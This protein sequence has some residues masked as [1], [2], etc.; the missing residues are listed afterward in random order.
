MVIVPDTTVKL[1]KNV[2]LNNTYQH[3]IYFSSLANQSAFFSGKQKFSLS[4]YSFVKTTQALRVGLSIGQLY[5]VNYMMFQNS[6]FNSKWFYAFITNVE[7]VNNECTEIT[8]ELDA[9]QSWFFEMQLKPSFVVREHAA[10]DGIGENTVPEGDELGV[11]TSRN[12]QAVSL[13]TDATG[14]TSLDIIVFFRSKSNPN[15]TVQNNIVSPL[16]KLTFSLSDPGGL[17]AFN[18]MLQNYKD[19]PEAIVAIYEVPTFINANRP[20]RNFNYIWNKTTIDGY[21]PKNNKLF[22]YPYNYLFASNHCGATQ[23]YA[24]ENFS[25]ASAEFL[26]EGTAYSTPVVLC[27]PK[28]YRNKPVDRDSGI[29]YSNFPSIPWVG[30]SFQEM[31]GQHK[32]QLAT[33]NISAALNGAIGVASTIGNAAIGNVAG[34]GASA[35]S[36][37]TSLLSQGGQMYDLMHKPPSTYNLGQVDSLN[38]INGACGFNFSQVQVSANM[39]RVID[40]KFSAYGYATHRLKQ[41][42]THTR[43]SWNFV[44]LSSPVIWG[45]AP[46]QFVKTYAA[47]LENGLTFWKDGD[48]VG[49]YTQDNQP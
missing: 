26:L 23:T 38:Y 18:D 21:T 49:D 14:N 46:A 13:I 22:T 2:P 1:L 47:A 31:L 12:S 17:G 20:Q 28:L 40:D 11:V 43:P 30:N 45:N 32:G 24:F 37:V 35:V 33:Q 36:T 4:N 34:A 7:Y 5:D 39:A 15:A 10:S 41:P 44:Q 6:A 19:D 3:T 9:I 8:F 29:S 16:I 25:S 48:S 27:S 42:N